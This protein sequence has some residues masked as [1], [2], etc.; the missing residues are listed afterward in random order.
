VCEPDS[1]AASRGLALG[2]RRSGSD[3]GL[4]EA[5]GSGSGSA[6]KVV[7]KKLATRLKV[8]LLSAGRVCID[9]IRAGGI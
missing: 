4:G 3:N 1:P 9:D 8:M 7:T 6:V 5:G 2:R